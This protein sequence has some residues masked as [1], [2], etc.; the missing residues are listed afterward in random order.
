MKPVLNKTGAIHYVDQSSLISFIRE[1]SQMAWND[2]NNFVTREH[3]G[4]DE[5][6]PAFW[7]KDDLTKTP[8]EFNEHQLFWIGNFFEAHPWI[9][10]MVIVF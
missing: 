1:N 2:I 7:D 5:F 10:R 9:E 6:G 4:A 8:D 3:I